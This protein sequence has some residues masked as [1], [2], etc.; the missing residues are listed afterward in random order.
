MKLFLYIILTTLPLS[1]YSAQPDTTTKASFH[2]YLHSSIGSYS[3]PTYDDWL[4]DRRSVSNTKYGV[5]GEIVINE[6]YTFSVGY[7]RL[8]ANNDLNYNNTSFA[9]IPV[10]F[11][12][13]DSVG[14]LRMDMYSGF[15]IYKSTSQNNA[16]GHGDFALTTL[17]FATDVP[18]TSGLFRFGLGVDFSID[19]IGLDDY[20]ELMYQAGDFTSI[21]ASLSIDIF[22]FIKSLTRRK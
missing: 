9:I 8:N 4:N 16:Y 22:P 10:L 18:W 20:G 7:I 17:M 3:L 6:S 5:M 14:G 2:L 19:G 15:K 11:G 13:T 21:E 12:V 1:L